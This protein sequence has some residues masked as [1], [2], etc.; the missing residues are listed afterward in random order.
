MKIRK[1]Y[2]FTTIFCTILTVLQFLQIKIQLYYII[3]MGLALLFML[4]GFTVKEL[5]KYLKEKYNV[6]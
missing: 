1:K 4:G 5:I 3:G 2:L 6:G